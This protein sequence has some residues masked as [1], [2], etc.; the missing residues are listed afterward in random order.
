[1]I[2]FIIISRITRIAYTYL[3]K[4]MAIVIVLFLWYIIKDFI[5]R[6]HEMEAIYGFRNKCAPGIFCAGKCRIKFTANRFSSRRARMNSKFDMQFYS[7]WHCHLLKTRFYKYINF[8]GLGLKSRSRQPSDSFRLMRK[9][10]FCHIL[11]Y[12]FIWI[13]FTTSLYFKAR[14]LNDILTETP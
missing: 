2:A 10:P 4:K 13:S 6:N 8:T 5:K 12:I 1:M 11:G 9:L 7:E 3:W 14:A